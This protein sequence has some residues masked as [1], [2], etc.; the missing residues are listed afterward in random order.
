LRH[1]YGVFESPKDIGII[2]ISAKFGKIY[3]V[4]ELARNP[5]FE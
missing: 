2:S 1:L 4:F 5:L 3:E